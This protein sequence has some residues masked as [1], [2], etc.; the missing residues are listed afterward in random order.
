[1]IC[2]MVILL[3]PSGSRIGEIDNELLCT[4]VNLLLEAVACIL[5]IESL[6]P[7]QHWGGDGQG[8]GSIDYKYCCPI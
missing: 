6:G 8:I 5:V 1:M 4:S 7:H 3:V 2:G